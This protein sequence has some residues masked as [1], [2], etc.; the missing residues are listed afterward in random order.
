MPALCAEAH[1]PETAGRL[2]VSLLRGSDGQPWV[3]KFQSNPQSVRALANE[4]LATPLGHLL[5]LPMPAVEV[6]EVPDWLQYGKA[7]GIPLHRRPRRIDLRLPA[8]FFSFYS[9]VHEDEWDRICC[10]Q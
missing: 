4:M 10:P 8:R 7:T 3:V 9:H 1:I 5:H 6:I 2:A